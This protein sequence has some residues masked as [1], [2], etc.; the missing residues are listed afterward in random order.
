MAKVRNAR[1][2]RT[3]SLDKQAEKEKRSKIYTTECI[4]QIV[5]EQSSGGA[6]DMDPF[7]HGQTDYR[8]S[9]IAFEYTDKELLELQRCSDDCLYF[10]SNYAKFLN[11]KGRT[12]VQLRDYQKNLLSLMSEEKYDEVSDTII[13]AN[14]EIV[15][16]QSRQT[17]KCVTGDTIIEIGDEYNI[18]YSKL[19]FKSYIKNL[20]KH[21]ISCFTR[22]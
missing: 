6:P 7:W 10:V 4:E 8:D 1:D 19:T 16:M 3:N 13:P 5:K 20:V 17:G 18:D 12:T 2:V 21:I 22:K 11:D 9:G 14:H 15:I